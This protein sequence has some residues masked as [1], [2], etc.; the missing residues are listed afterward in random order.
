MPDATKHTDIQDART[1]EDALKIA[2]TRAIEQMEDYARKAVAAASEGNE[3]LA[4]A[5]RANE[6]GLARTAAFLG[7]LLHELNENSQRAEFNHT[8]SGVA[9]CAA[10]LHMLGE[11]DRRGSKGDSSAP[12]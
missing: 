8:N 5:C 7:D 2:R 6:D 3:Q 9:W 10:A 12:V 1:P 4:D 11:I